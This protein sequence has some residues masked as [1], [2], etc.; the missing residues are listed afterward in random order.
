MPSFQ[1]ASTDFG[2][3]TKIGT[4]PLQVGRLRGGW[5]EGLEVAGLLGALENTKAQR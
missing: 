5:L 3:I 1:E 4:T 2:R